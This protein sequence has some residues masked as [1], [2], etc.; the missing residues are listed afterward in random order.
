MRANLLRAISHDLRTPLTS[1]IGSA[2]LYL[3][4]G[5]MMQETEKFTLIHNIHE[6]ANW[7]LNMVENILSVTRINAR[8]CKGDQD[9]RAGRGGC[10]RS[11]YPT[12]KADNGC[13]YPCKG[14]G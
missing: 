11:R 12:E 13:R 8:R 4:N 9:R 7:L 6:D 1:I 2:N 14:T 10:L 3:E 5:A